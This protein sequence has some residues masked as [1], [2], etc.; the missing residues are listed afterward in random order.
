MEVRSVHPLTRMFIFCAGSSLDL[1][2]QCPRSEWIKHTGIGV[3]VFFTALLA[4]LSS[5]YAFQLIFPDVWISCVLSLIWGAIILN[6]DRY[7][8]SSF[9]MNQTWK[10]ELLQLI[11]RLIM[12]VAI[13]IVISKPL[14]VEVFKLEINQVL[15][16]DK[17]VLV[18]SLTHQYHRELEQ[19]DAK[20]GVLKKEL[21]GYFDLKEAYYREYICECDGTC[22]TGQKGRGIECFAKKEKYESFSAEFEQHKIRIDK[23]IQ[24]IEIEKKKLAASF[25]KNKKT[26]EDIFSYGFL[27]RLNALGKLDSLAS[28]AITLLLAL[29]EITPVL[30]KF[31]APKGPYDHLLQMG[32]YDYKVKYVQTVYKKNQEFFQMSPITSEAQ[33]FSQKPDQKDPSNAQTDA[34]ERYRKLKEYLQKKQNS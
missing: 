33:Q 11:P 23:S 10:E 20:V 27:A 8:V 25:E 2:Y 7:I 3:T 12:A 16:S 29:V 19:W 4:V 15:G 13:S 14:E 9:R 6:L 26:M 22:G 17:I 30:T 1:L 21:K 31:F 28:I 32:E 34:T 24:D 18:D 5:F